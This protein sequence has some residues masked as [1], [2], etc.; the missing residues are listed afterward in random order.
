MERILDLNADLD[1]ALFDQVV[2]TFYRSAG[3]Q[4][5]SRL[6]QQQQAKQVLEQFQEHPDAW[7]RVDG[8]LEHCSQM[9]SKVPACNPVHCAANPRKA[10]Q[11]HVESSPDASAPGHQEFHCWFHYS[12]LIG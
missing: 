5:G 7:K 2:S 6:T 10:H 11:N 8:I 9:E 4:V 12:E 3:A 1:A